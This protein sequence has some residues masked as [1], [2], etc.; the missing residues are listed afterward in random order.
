RASTSRCP[1]C[2]AAV[3]VPPAYGDALALLREQDEARRRV[4]PHLRRLQ[5][6]PGKRWIILGAGLVA[7]L[8]PFAVA[9]V[10]ALADDALSQADYISLAALPA[11]APGAA[12][13]FAA[14]ASRVTSMQVMTAMAARLIEG[15]PCCRV[16]GA[17]LAVEPDAL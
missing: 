1:Y 2:G 11:L 12:V 8:P 10:V 17:P 7:L 5:R 13:A 4:E 3:D 6:P 15:E 14:L 9:V 16:C